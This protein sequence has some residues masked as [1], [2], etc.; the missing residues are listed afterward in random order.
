[1]I[2]ALECGASGSV[3]QTTGSIEA[4]SNRI[5]V[6]DS[7]DFRPGQWVTVDECHIGIEGFVYNEKEP[8][9]EKN[10][11]PLA[12]ELEI[13][14]FNA[15]KGWQVFV[16]HFEETSPATFS[17]LAVDPEC[18]P[19]HRRWQWQ[20]RDLA[21]QGE[22]V[23]LRDGVEIR[24][25]KKDWKPG[26]CVSFHA[27]SRLL[28]R[29]EKM[30]G[31]TVLLADKA[32][33]SNGRAL[34]RHH[35]G[36]ALQAAVDRAVSANK[37][38]FIP[39]GY[40]RLDRGLF[41]KDANLR[42]EGEHADNT[43]LD[44]G[45]GCGAVFNL[46]GGKS[47]KVRNL[48][49]RGHTGFNELPW[50][51]FKTATG[52]SFWPTANQQMEV[53]GC[54]AAN[55]KGTESVLFEDVRVE[56]M[57]A[58]A[59]YSQG[60]SREGAKQ[61]ENG[62]LK[63]Y[64]RS[65]TYHRCVVEDCASNAFNNNDLA[66]NTSIL[67]CRVERVHNFWEGANRYTRVIGNYVRN[68]HL[69]SYGNVFSRAEVL[70]IFGTGQTVIT[71]NVFEGG[72]FG[73]GISI[74]I[75]PTQIIISNN[76][77]TNFSNGKAIRIS[78][79]PGGNRFPARYVNVAGNV[80]DLTHVEG[81][82]DRERTGIAISASNVIVADNQ[83]YVREP[84]GGKVTG[85]MIASHCVNLNL[86]DNLIRGCAHAIRRGFSRTLYTPETGA[87]EGEEYTEQAGGR[88]VEILDD[89][90]FRVEG[91][92]GAWDD[93]D[94]QG[95][96]LQWTGGAKAG[97]ASEIQRFDA[98]NVVVGVVSSEGITVGDSFTLHPADARWS[99]HHNNV[100]AGLIEEVGEGPE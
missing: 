17:W 99:I 78:G 31:K 44:I 58:E 37:A 61:A 28:T 32:N 83:I 26:Q 71:D 11:A 88:V 33:R 39:S 72:V 98:D 73:D 56:R 85:I 38:L 95:W 15:G 51:K 24:F 35:D 10:R 42:V 41:V 80:I 16:L 94:Y 54:A 87:Y 27:R 82:L 97:T 6:A 40:Y 93:A 46:V 48:C 4:G 100:D 81:Q 76:I 47:V 12:G 69:G 34:V 8:Y 21:V 75:G 60:P 29:I 65:I 66:E 52:H 22:W 90:R 19:N 36:A 50:Y 23:S 77:F 62:L 5:V 89:N 14:G 3:F 53:K 67:H 74:G 49:M 20:G 9:F 2:H 13:R 1:M 57:S 18:Q 84:D 64:T 63:G 7:G 43:V 91:I 59:F 70:K 55:I 45:E 25:A 79:Y 68:A 96:T 92:P 86:H 30:E